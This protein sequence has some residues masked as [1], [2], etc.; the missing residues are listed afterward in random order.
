MALPKAIE[1]E[2]ERIRAKNEGLNL[3]VGESER[4]RGFVLHVDGRLDTNNSNDFRELASSALLEAHAFGGMVIELSK[5]SY[6]SSTGVGALTYL[7]AEAKRHEI[8]FYL[9]GMTEH[10][11]AVFDVLGF[12]SFFSCIDANGEKQQ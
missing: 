10:T 7:L 4:P 9:Q 3:S 11:K 5:V 12:T 6:I 2:I 8:L 1:A